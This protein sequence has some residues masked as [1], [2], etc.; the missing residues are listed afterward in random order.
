MTFLPGR[1]QALSQQPCTF[2]CSLARPPGQPATLN[3]PHVELSPPPPC[4]DTPGS[5]VNSSQAPVSPTQAA[6]TG[7]VAT[8]TY[9]CPAFASTPSHHRAY[10]ALPTP[11]DPVPPNWLLCLRCFP[12]STDLHSKGTL[13]SREHRS[14]LSPSRAG[15]PSHTPNS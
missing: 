9:R 8:Q 11:T 4:T 7:S 6:H 10:T 2:S 14:A 5:S 13:Q 3:P 15:T 12:L 1:G